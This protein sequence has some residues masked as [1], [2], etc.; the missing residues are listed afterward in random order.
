MSIIIYCV[1][2]N[3]FCTATHPQSLFILCCWHLTFIN[4]ICS[5]EIFFLIS[6]NVLDSVWA[7]VNIFI[8]YTKETLEFNVLVKKK[9]TFEIF[10]VTAV[11]TCKYGL[12][13]CKNIC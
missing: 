13:I 7:H 4:V 2:H 9:N 1:L 8:L 12:Q 10:C 6:F 5:V 11:P 3:W